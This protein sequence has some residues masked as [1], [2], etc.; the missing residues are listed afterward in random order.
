MTEIQIYKLQYVRGKTYC[1]HKNN[2][3]NRHSVTF[4]QKQQHTRGKTTKRE[5][6]QWRR[7]GHKLPENLRSLVLKRTVKTYE[8]QCLPRLV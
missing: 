6:G 4:I 2:G 8:N 3:S 7:R 1:E 5:K